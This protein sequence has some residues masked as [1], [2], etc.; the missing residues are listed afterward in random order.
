MNHRDDTQC[1]KLLKKRPKSVDG[2]DKHFEIDIS[3]SDLFKARAHLEFELIINQFF[4]FMEE[5]C[6]SNRK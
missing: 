3:K 4:A 2:W 5:S 6:G 1:L